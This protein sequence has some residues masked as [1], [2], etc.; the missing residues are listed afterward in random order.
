LSIASFAGL[1]MRK[2]G[3]GIRRKLPDSSPPHPELVEGRTAADAA[4]RA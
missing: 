2:N 4:A 1:G 3:D